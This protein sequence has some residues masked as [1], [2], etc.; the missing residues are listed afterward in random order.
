MGLVR[1]DLNPRVPDFRAQL[2]AIIL[3]SPKVNFFS[4][5]SL[6]GT[7]TYGNEHVATFILEFITLE[8]SL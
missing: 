5:P 6:P 4:P 8:I 7:E 1:L 3:H 2:L